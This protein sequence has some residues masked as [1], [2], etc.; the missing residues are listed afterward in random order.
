[1]V[2]CQQYYLRFGGLCNRTQ[3]F[4]TGDKNNSLSNQAVIVMIVNIFCTYLVF[5]LSLFK[6]V[7]FLKRVVY[8]KLL[9]FGINHL[10]VKK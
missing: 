5:L 7:H 2:S 1:M 8:I 6:M 3:N 10:P 9:L 4:H